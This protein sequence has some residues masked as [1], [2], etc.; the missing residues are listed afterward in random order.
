MNISRLEACYQANVG[1]TAI[2]V[3]HL[4]TCLIGGYSKFLVAEIRYGY[5]HKNW[6][7]VDNMFYGPI[8]N[9]FEITEKD[10]IWMFGNHG[11]LEKL[12]QFIEQ[13]KHQMV[14]MDYKEPTA[15]QEC[16]A[17]MKIQL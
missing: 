9:H 5:L 13:H 15:P 16:L 7:S 11:A 10:A 17:P 12:R 14:E 3:L 8:A 6:T 2:D 4:D 1:R